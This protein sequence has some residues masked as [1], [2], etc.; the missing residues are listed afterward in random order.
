MKPT[1]HQVKPGH[2]RVELGTRA[3]DVIELQGRWYINQFPEAPI[4]CGTSQSAAAFAAVVIL[5]A[6]SSLELAA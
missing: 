5:E 4:D 1:Q 6:Q 3:F 2:F